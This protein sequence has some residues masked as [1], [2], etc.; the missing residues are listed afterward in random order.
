MHLLFFVEEPSA[1]A[2]LGNLM[3]KCLPV[4]VTYQF[5]VF[6]GKQDL[7]HNLSSRL[8]AYASWLPEDYRIIVLIDE[9]R[10]DCHELKSQMEEAA[11]AAGLLSKSQA[12][13]RPFQ[14]L[15]RIAVEE[16]EAWFFGDI[17]ALRQVYPRLPAT[18]GKRKGL[19]DPDAIS[20]GTWETLQQVLQRYGYYPAGYP[21]VQAAQ[22]ISRQMAPTR[23][24]SHSFQVFYSGLMALLGG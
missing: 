21:K 7:L 24:R 11:L 16:L 12:E 3:R 5:I 18:L 14:V 10:Q 23:N 13:E 19:R 9:D 22:E 15:N 4:E 8:K 1:E 2:A 6:Q 20:G 17:D